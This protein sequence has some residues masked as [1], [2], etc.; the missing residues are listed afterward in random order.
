MWHGLTV[1]SIKTLPDIGVLFEKKEPALIA[2][3]AERLAVIGEPQNDV[4]QKFV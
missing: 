2:R 1:Y 4:N 3:A